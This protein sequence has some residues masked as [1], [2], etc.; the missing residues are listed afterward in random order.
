MKQVSQLTNQQLLNEVNA[1][2]DRAK[3][4]EQ[5]NDVGYFLS[6]YNIKKGKS[7]VG[8]ILLYRLYKTWSKKPQ[9]KYSFKLELSNYFK[10]RNKKYVLISMEAINITK[11]TYKKLAQKEEVITDSKYVKFFDEFL[12]YYNVT[13]GTVWVSS[14]DLYKAAK[15]YSNIKYR[16]NIKFK[17]NEFVNYMKLYVPYQYTTDHMF[18][19]NDVG[20][21]SI[22]DELRRIKEANEKE[23]KRS[24]VSRI[25]TPIKS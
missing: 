16:A 12:D 21:L 17:T 11:A 9:T 19:I 14:K 18:R 4:T 1:L 15:S 13:S 8:Y 20:S 23:P 3:I 25:E 6:L 22:I 7:L 5:I 2:P 10:I 24:K